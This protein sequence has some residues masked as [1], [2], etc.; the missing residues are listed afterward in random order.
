MADE[1]TDQGST[2]SENTGTATLEAPAKKTSPPERKSKKLPPYK[3]LLHN[4][5]VNSFERVIQCIVQLTSVAPQEA[6]LKAL[7]AHESGVALLVVTHKERAELYV[8]QF[9]SVSLTVTMEPA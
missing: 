3:V 6:L 5:D 2:D 4:D 7:E 1:M 8:D 9:T